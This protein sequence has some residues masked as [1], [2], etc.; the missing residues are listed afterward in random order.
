MS[1]DVDELYQLYYATELRW[2]Q[3]RVKCPSDAEDI[4]ADAFVKICAYRQKYPDRMINY[5]RTWLRTIIANCLTDHYRYWSRRP[6]ISDMDIDFDLDDLPDCNGDLIE[7]NFDDDWLAQQDLIERLRAVVEHADL[8]EREQY[9][10]SLRLSG[11]RYQDI[12]DLLNLTS[13]SSA[14][15]IFFRAKRRLN[16][17]VQSTTIPDSGYHADCVT[18]S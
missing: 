3:S 14:R 17:L 13:A 18:L 10:L 16:N 2:L 15:G 1:A 6:V 11:Y 4:L 12:A 8:P 9:L 7:Q 5:P